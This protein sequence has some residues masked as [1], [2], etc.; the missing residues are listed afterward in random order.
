MYH[1]AGKFAD[2]DK[3]GVAYSALEAAFRAHNFRAHLTRLQLGS[4]WY[5]SVLHPEEG[6]V[7][8]AIS[9]IITRELSRGE[10]CQLP[11]E[12]VNAII[13]RVNARRRAGGGEYISHT[14]TKVS[15]R[16]PALQDSETGEIVQS[17]PGQ[18]EI[19]G[20]TVYSEDAQARARLDEM[21][22][23]ASLAESMARVLQEQGEDAFMQNDAPEEIKGNQR[24]ILE[25]VRKLRP[26]SPRASRAD[27]A[28]GGRSFDAIAGSG[29]PALPGLQPGTPLKIT[30]IPFI[31][32][33]RD[34]QAGVVAGTPD[35]YQIARNAGVGRL[36]TAMNALI[37]RKLRRADKYQFD[38]SA[39]AMLETVREP[40]AQDW[41]PLQNNLWIEFRQALNSPH[42]ADIKA[43]WVHSM[44]TDD[45]IK[46]V[47]PPGR[48]L[49]VYRLM[50]ERNALYRGYWSFDVITTRCKEL[51]DF[52]YEPAQG[53]YVYLYSHVCPY[54]KCEYT[55]P[56]TRYTLGECSPC[57]E[58]R[59]A[60][61]HWA[62]VL[63]TAI[64]II[65]REYALAP[66]EPRPWAS[67]PE[68]YTEETTVKIGK[69]KHQHEKRKE[70]VREVDYRLVKFEVSELGYPARA[71]GDEIVAQAEQ[72]AQ[73]SKRPNWLKLAQAGAPDTIIWEYREIDTSKGRTL[74]PQHNPRWKA[75]KHVEIAPYKKWIPMLSRERKTIKRVTARRYTDQK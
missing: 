45:D 33:Y 55:V 73:E 30:T 19:T 62:S 50:I 52:T 66:Q 39:I 59:A 23:P 12:T 68:T 48:D 3:A 6:K 31:I 26:G 54:G 24:E 1:I 10:I 25:L 74:D 20:E 32:G 51:F 37:A 11:E 61:A 63:H 47:A 71:L 14:P 57:P 43:L 28:Q 22:I 35:K 40:S 36:E 69:G 67:A 13:Q 16:T 2:K 7:T 41:L 44:D 60:L 18:V 46:E 72:D 75:Y 38:Q 17:F 29:S 70:V 34:M 21:G 64:R 65:R 15:Y 42:G 4:D 9:T 8:P 58:C 53:R 49:Q 56:E 5:V 27:L